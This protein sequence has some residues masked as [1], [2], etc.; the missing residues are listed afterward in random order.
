MGLPIVMPSN[1][2]KMVLGLID[3]YPGRLGNLYSQSSWLLPKGLNYALDNDRYSV[4]SAG[5]KWDEDRYWDFLGRVSKWDTRPM[6]AAVPDVV[7]NPEDTI[8]WYSKWS[9][10]IIDSFGFNIAVVVQDGMTAEDVNRLVPKPNVVFIGGT[11]NWKWKYLRMWKKHFDRVH[12]GRVNTGNLLWRVHRAGVESSDG[13]GWWHHKQ[14]TQLVRYLK[15]SSSGMTEKD[16]AP[17]PIK[18]RD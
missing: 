5:K 4:W 16:I 6:W 8:R 9:R 15:R 11:T 12:V 2:R 17:M 3:K 7:A 14:Y 13:T 10:K 1:R 18:W